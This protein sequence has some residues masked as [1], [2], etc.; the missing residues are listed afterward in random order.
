M[1]LNVYNRRR[2]HFIFKVKEATRILSDRME[3]KKIIIFTNLLNISISSFGIAYFI[4]P[5]SGH[6][7]SKCLRQN[8]IGKSKD[9]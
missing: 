9:F 1:A 2:N 7:Q 3:I 4:S 6:F 5:L 8:Q